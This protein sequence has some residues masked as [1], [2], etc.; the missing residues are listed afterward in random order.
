MN[1]PTSAVGTVITPRD[2]IP[3]FADLPPILR[4]MEVAFSNRMGSVVVTM[5]SAKTEPQSMYEY[6]FVRQVNYRSRF[7][8]VGA[9]KLT[10]IVTKLR[11][12]QTDV[13]SADRRDKILQFSDVH[14]D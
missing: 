6:H 2:T 4:D 12:F 3:H 14:L 10:D 8:R 13:V 9:F 11:L 1:I 7:D 5:K